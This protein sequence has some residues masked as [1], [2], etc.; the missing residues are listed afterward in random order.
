MDAKQR[1]ITVLPHLKIAMQMAKIQVP[2]GTV[3]IGI[4]AEENNGGGRITAQFEGEQ[5]IEDIIQV[6]GFKDY[7]DFIAQAV[8]E[9]QEKHTDD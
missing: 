8:A 4:I 2:N 5:F 1:L 9:R 3:R 7:N 6:L